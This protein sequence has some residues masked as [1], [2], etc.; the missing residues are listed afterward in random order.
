MKTIYNINVK[1]K[2]FNDP[3]FLKAE[4]WKAI[5]DVFSI[6]TVSKNT[7]ASRVTDLF[8]LHSDI[9]YLRQVVWLIVKKELNSNT[10][11]EQFLQ[12]TKFLGI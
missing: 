5:A 8:K 3:R 4:I 6:E 2:S 7:R 9:K 1:T 11:L 10:T 12:K